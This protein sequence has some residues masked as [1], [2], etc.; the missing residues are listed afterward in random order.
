MLTDCRPNVLT[1][2]P[3]VDYV[4]IGVGAPL[5][6]GLS[7][8]MRWPVGRR[9][10]LSLDRLWDRSRASWFLDIWK[11]N[12]VVFGVRAPLTGG[13]SGFTRWPVGRRA[14]LSPDHLWD[15]SRAS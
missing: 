13:L 12:Y 6:G 14:S 5:T 7:G 8:F 15:R 1:V 4:V 3:V 9:A 2:H 10:P 11:V